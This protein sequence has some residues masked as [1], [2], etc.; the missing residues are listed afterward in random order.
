[1]AKRP[2][3]KKTVDPEA[4]LPRSGAS[5]GQSLFFTL[6]EEIVTGRIAAGES[7]REIKIAKRYNVSRTPV[8]EALKKLQTEGLIA[9]LPGQG[10]TVVD[11]S[12]E[13]ISDFYLIREVLEGLGARLAAQR[14]RDT[15]IM[16]LKALLQQ[17]EESDANEQTERTIA[18]TTQFDQQVFQAARN[19]RLF[20]M[21]EALRASQGHS[22]RGNMQD[23]ERRAQS[24]KERHV[25]VEALEQRDESKAEDA[26]KDHLRKARQHR[27]IA[28]LNRVTGR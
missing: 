4:G 2:V 1:M 11:P 27:M 18:L 23:K 28:L 20:Q 8:R 21:I 7:L 22:R 10:V 19:P 5:L 9:D 16:I 24:L 17:A 13:E 26:A 3:K 6:R 15:E 25:L 14:G 12:L